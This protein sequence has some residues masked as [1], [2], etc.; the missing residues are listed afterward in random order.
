MKIALFY[1]FCF[2]L[3]FTHSFSQKPV[4]IGIAGLSHSHV[5]P[6]LRNMDREDIQ[7]VGIAER[8]TALSQRYAKA[9]GIDR[10]LIFQS[11]DE[12][13]EQ[14]KPQGVITFTSIFEHLKV[15]EACAPLGIDVMVE[16]PLAVSVRH[17]KRMAELAKKHGILLLTNYETTWYPS[18][19]E[20]AE[21][22][23]NGDLG[24]LRKIIV[25]DGHKGPKEIRVNTEFLDWL[26]DPVLNGGGAVTDFGCYGADLITWILKG[27]KPLSVIAQLKQYK[28]D[29]YPKVDDDAT[30]ILS[31]P[32]MEG[33]IHASWNWPFN[34]KDM[35][36]Y[37]TTGYAFLDDSETIRYR[38]DEKSKE[39]TKKI[40]QSKA[41]FNDPFTFF[42]SAI[43]GETKVESTDLSSLEINVTVVEILEAA[44][45]S[46]KTG[47]RVQLGK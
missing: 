47:K 21:M 18:N 46:S 42:A 20:G 10:K 40:P 14:T 6:L 43:K 26:T 1:I 5:V 41:P 13:L 23:N 44:R 27:E 33:V 15:V 22:I 24:K 34:R 25:Y 31:Y 19:Y 36:V 11:L 9:Y 38:L 7:I 29:V 2:S 17:A 12:M 45:K 28:P 35:H 3:F 37:G 16:K 30:I 39:L 4:R 32:T 8:D